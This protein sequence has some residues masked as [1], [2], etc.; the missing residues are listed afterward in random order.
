[1]RG[2]HFVWRALETARRMN[3]AEAGEAAP[4][5][6]ASGATRRAVLKALAATGMA[7][8]LSRPAFA[9]ARRVAIVG[10]GIAGLSALHHLREAGVDAWLYEARGRTGGRMFTHQS[11]EDRKSVV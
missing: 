10:G 2:N 4:I 3:L 11:G 8:T 1:M 7:S 5:K 9:R 6:A